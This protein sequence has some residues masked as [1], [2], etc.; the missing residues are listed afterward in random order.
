MDEIILLRRKMF[1]SGLRSKNFL[2]NSQLSVIQELYNKKRLV[3]SVIK[4]ENVIQAISFILKE[5]SN[6]LFWIDIYNDSKL[7]NLYNYVMAISLLSSE[8]DVL[9]NFGRGVYQYKSKNFLP[10]VYQLYSIN[11]FFSKWD[12][13]MF[14]TKSIFIRI[15]RFI[16]KKITK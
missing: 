5:G 7:I 13:I 1:Q 11:I 3:L 10:S 8:K 16:Y 15:L 4:K 12:E 6:Y 2:T 14:N 9:I